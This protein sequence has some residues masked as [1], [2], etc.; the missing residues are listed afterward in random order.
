MGVALTLGNSFFSAIDHIIEGI[1]QGNH[2]LFIES[3][4]VHALIHMFLLK[5]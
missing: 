1:E 4:R 5:K 3:D 2:F